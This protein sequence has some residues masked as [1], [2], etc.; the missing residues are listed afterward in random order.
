MAGG[1][2]LKVVARACGRLTGQPN[3]PPPSQ[4]EKEDEDEY[5]NNFYFA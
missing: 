2:K 1:T 3:L 4:Q 5:A